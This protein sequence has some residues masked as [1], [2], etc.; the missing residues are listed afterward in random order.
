M[1]II[2]LTK[3]VLA[4][5]K[6]QSKFQELNHEVYCSKVFLD[7]VLMEKAAGELK[8]FDVAIL[9]ESIPNKEVFEIGPILRQL[10]IKVLRKT[11][12][13]VSEQETDSIQEKVVDGWISNI[14]TKD[15]LREDLC[16]IKKT[17]LLP[18]T[19]KGS[20]FVEEN[21]D[22]QEF[23]QYLS[24]MEREV[25]DRLFSS[26][27]ECVLRKHLYACLWQHEPTTS[28][29]V[30]LSALIRKL[31]IKI[32]KFNQLD[33]QIVTVHGAG[34]KLECGVAI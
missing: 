10:G 14:S 33:V 4:E 9:S 21:Y 31:R 23:R 1:K 12:N 20:D 7:K 13:S 6:L 25:F 22:F 3:N 2:I 18:G 34:Y 29:V 17:L 28:N 5:V 30:H 32:R 27:G 15:T 16:Q 24:T 19:I 11:A 8:I 26:R